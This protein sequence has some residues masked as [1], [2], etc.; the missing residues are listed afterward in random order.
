MPRGVEEERST[1]TPSKETHALYEAIRA[2][3]GPEER[4]RDDDR[5]ASRRRRRAQGAMPAPQRSRLR[6]GV[7]PFLATRSLREDN[8]AFSL[9]QEIAA[10][11]ARFRWFDVIAPVSLSPRPA[12]PRSSEDALQHKQ[13]DYVVDGALSCNG[14]QFQISVR[15][16]DITRYAR[17][18]WSERFELARRRAAPGSNE[19]VTGTHRRADRPG[20]PVHRGTAEAARAVWRDRPSAARRSADLQH[21]AREVRGGRDS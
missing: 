14:K 5:A 9:S 17:P 8:L 16:L 6:V 12:E 19:M 11:L 21:G 13:L 3:R 1:S 2:L 10:A 20:H 4:E 18:V 15:L 7:L